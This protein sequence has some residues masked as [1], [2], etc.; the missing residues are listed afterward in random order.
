MSYPF[1]KD[2]TIHRNFAAKLW[3]YAT[4]TAILE[5]NDCITPTEI[6]GR[7]E[8]FVIALNELRKNETSN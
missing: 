3:N 5:F 7:I 8:E 6:D 2:G 1:K 4:E